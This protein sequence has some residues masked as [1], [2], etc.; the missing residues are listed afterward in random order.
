MILQEKEMLGRCGRMIREEGEG[1]EEKEIRREMRWK[2][3]WLKTTSQWR[4][5]LSRDFCEVR[6]QGPDP[7]EEK[8]READVHGA[9][10][11]SGRMVRNEVRGVS[12][13]TWWTQINPIILI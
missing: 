13:E 9:H 1:E 4:W 2:T 7:W 3:R 8:T 12:Q 5:H 10:C 11:T 6:K